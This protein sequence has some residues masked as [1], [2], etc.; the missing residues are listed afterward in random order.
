MPEPQP[1]LDAVKVVQDGWNTKK[2]T[3]LRCAS[4]EA[5]ADTTP[6]YILR[7]ICAVADIPCLIEGYRWRKTFPSSLSM[8]KLVKNMSPYSMNDA[9]GA[10]V[11]NRVKHGVDCSAHTPH[12]SAKMSHLLRFCS[13][14]FDRE[15]R[16]TPFAHIL[17][18][19]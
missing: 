5:T 11:Q 19:A 8:V 14:S 18:D 15:Y 12:V 17:A 7:A 1:A 16:G 3:V 13:V 4:T 6:L 9:K 2:N 10:I